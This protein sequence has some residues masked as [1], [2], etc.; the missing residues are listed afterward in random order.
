MFSRAHSAHL[1]S[2]ADASICCSALSIIRYAYIH[3]K[4]SH[5][6]LP[7]FEF[8]TC[9]HGKASETGF[10]PRDGKK[11][12]LKSQGFVRTHLIVIVSPLHRYMLTTTA[13]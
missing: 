11:A 2:R 3:G 7:P 12:R 10:R 5:C 1:E 6:S 9:R 13:L 8:F 4:K